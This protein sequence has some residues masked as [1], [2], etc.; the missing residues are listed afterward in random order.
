MIVEVREMLPQYGRS[1]FRLAGLSGAVAVGM[2]AYGA[3]G[4]YTTERSLTLSDHE[5]KKNFASS[6]VR[7]RFSVDNH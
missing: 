5:S 1:Y 4:Q 2:G 7:F 3:H 6:R